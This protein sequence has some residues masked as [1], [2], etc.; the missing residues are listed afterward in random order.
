MGFK[1]NSADMDDVLR[2]AAAII[3]SETL[4]DRCLGRCFARRGTRLTNPE[5]GRALRVTLAM[6]NDQAPI[7]REECP[8]CQG[9][10]RSVDPWAERA[11]EAVH[12]VEFETYL[13][14]TH[15]PPAV[16]QAEDELWPRHGLTR[17]RAEPIKQE[18]NREMG[19]AF[20]RKLAYHG[21][22]VTVD[23]REPQIVCLVDFPTDQLQLTIH[24]LFVYGRY[25]KL[26][27]GIP[28]T[29]WPCKRCRGRGC[30]HCNQTG[31]QYP[32]S[33]E[34]LIAKPIVEAANGEGHALHGAGREDIDARMLG[35]GRPFVLEVYSPKLRTLDLETL[36]AEINAEASE[37]I[38]V[39]GL[40]NANRQTVREAK[41]LEARKRYRAWVEFGTTISPDALQRAVEPLVGADVQ[42]RTPTRVS[43]RRSD[44]VRQRRVHELSAELAGKREAVVELLGDGGLY[45]KEF[46]SGDDGRS[47]PSLAETLGVEARVTAL[48]VLAVEA[49]ISLEPR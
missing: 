42:Q 21:R 38:E 12:D 18:F 44:L 36:Q 10:F 16:K 34:E 32:E 9:I 15:V 33:V 3:T 17:G 48:D 27:R 6:I 24:S 11:V 23:F 2:D 45:V 26:V 49:Q 7:S 25:R 39:R 20:E 22:N 1:H 46:I 37:M 41:E 8:I 31:K 47:T 5:R 30:R 35:D 43:H 40:V 13:F 14:G 4:C 19:R 29:R 28:Q